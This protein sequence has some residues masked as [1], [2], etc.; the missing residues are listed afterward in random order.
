MF[1]RSGPPDIAKL[2]GKRAVGVLWDEQPDVRL[3]AAEALRQLREPWA[4]TSSSPG[5]ANA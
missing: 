2:R 1:G 5:L 3:T 4:D